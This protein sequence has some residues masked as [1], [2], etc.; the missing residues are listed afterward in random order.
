MSVSNELKCY[1]CGSAAST[2]SALHVLT[3]D[4]L[5]CSNYDGVPSECFSQRR[6]LRNNNKK[7]KAKEDEAELQEL[8]KKVFNLVEDKNKKEQVKAQYPT[9]IVRAKADIFSAKYKLVDD[10][11]TNGLFMEFVSQQNLVVSSAHSHEALYVVIVCAFATICSFHFIDFVHHLH[12]Y[13]YMYMFHSR[14]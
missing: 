1:F 11:L 12:H 8:R 13:V 2:I 3:L 6:I 5:L 9:F 7:K 10:D 4:Y 14:P